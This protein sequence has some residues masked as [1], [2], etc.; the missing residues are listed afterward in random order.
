MQK[1]QKLLRT[2]FILEE[3]IHA[4]HKARSRACYPFISSSC[5]AEMAVEGRKY[6][7]RFNSYWRY[8]WSKCAFTTFSS[9]SAYRVLGGAEVR[10]PVAPVFQEAETVLHHRGYVMLRGAGVLIPVVPVFQEVGAILRRRGADCLCGVCVEGRKYHNKFNSYFR[11]HRLKG[12]YRAG[13]FENVVPKMS[14]RLF[15]FS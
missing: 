8:F 4:A 7:N 1:Q 15:G 6:D 13:G 12:S 2:V 11:K 9:R 14:V 10:I 5:V 3:A